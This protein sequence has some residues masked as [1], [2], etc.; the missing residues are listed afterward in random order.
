MIFSNKKIVIT[1]F[2]FLFGF[3]GVSTTQSQTITNQVDK[4][5]PNNR[6]NIIAYNYRPQ[7]QVQ[8]QNI[9][10][11]S[12]NLLKWFERDPII[13]TSDDDLNTQGF[14]GSGTELDPYRIENVEIGYA[15]ANSHCIII[16]NTKKHLL[17]Q[18]NHLWG[19][20]SPPF[21]NFGSHSQNHIETNPVYDLSM[22]INLNNARNVVVQGN[23]LH[24]LTYAID[25]YNS[26]SIIVRN[27]RVSANWEYGIVCAYSRDIILKNNTS[28]NSYQGIGVSATFNCTIRENHCFN[29]ATGIK[30]DFNCTNFIIRN[31][32]CYNNYVG[33]EINKPWILQSSQRITIA[34][35]T[36]ENNKGPGIRIEDS[37]NNQITNNYC[38]ENNIGISIFENSINN[39]VKTNTCK[40]NRKG[41]TI[42]NSSN[43]VISQNNLFSNEQGIIIGKLARNNSISRNIIEE[44]SIGVYIHNGLNNSLSFNQFSLCD[45]AIF[46]EVGSKFN[47][48][49]WNA[50]FRTENN[51]AMDHGDNNVFRQNFWWD[52]NGLDFAS[53]LKNGS[54]QYNLVSYLTEICD[55]FGDTPF[56]I[57]GVSQN[58]DKSPLMR[59]VRF[60]GPRI[61]SIRPFNGTQHYL[62]Q[63]ILLT[64][65]G[66]A[67]F[68]Y[69][70]LQGCNMSPISWT[71]PV[72]IAV[73]E[74]GIFTLQVWAED[75][76]GGVNEAIIL[77]TV[78]NDEMTGIKNNV[79]EMFSEPIVLSF[80]LI[81]TCGS[82]FILGS[83]LARQLR[84]FLKKK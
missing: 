75:A 14:P 79:K 11:L 30:I 58:C 5:K 44:N 42:C 1:S 32:F 70:H 28:S 12:I 68:F 64:I 38:T 21:S 16:N 43:N 4:L 66:D 33:I 36:C 24:N 19:I 65:S 84:S 53:S 73:N 49:Q 78:S 59:P 41:I 51:S 23:F 9:E 77:F 81:G 67:I 47:L 40:N 20:R 61:T 50:I 55:G 39:T 6:D 60:E 80:V 17:I 56:F 76:I 22:G 83:F 31:N 37:L 48:V 27:N 13:I 63:T 54:H 72:G 35:N 46:I 34:N 3:L 29:H 2:I 74:T 45:T 71:G 8:N 82:S 52:Y 57:S 25:I 26:S 10:I 18:N 7:S 69:Y 15:A 62:T